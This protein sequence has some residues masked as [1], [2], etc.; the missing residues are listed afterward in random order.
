MNMDFQ[1]QRNLFGQLVFTGTDGVAHDGVEPARSFP[2]TAP[3]EGI[4]ILSRDGHELAWIPSLDQLDKET[5]GLIEDELEVR[6]FMPEIARIT[7]VSH[8][9]TQREHILAEAA[10][11]GLGNVRILTCDMNDFDTDAAAYDRV[12]SVEMF[13]H[14]KNWP[15]LMGN[16]A[17]WLRPGGLFFAHVFTHATTPACDRKLVFRRSVSSGSRRATIRGSSRA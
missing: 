3:R 12:V 15:R 1:L 14:M 13:E 6:E 8:S 4:S 11:R 7:G 16:I 5:R 2:I 17:R 9:R 10:R